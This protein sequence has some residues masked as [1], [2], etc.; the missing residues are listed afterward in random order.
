MW[1][2]SYVMRSQK[3]LIRV[4]NCAKGIPSMTEEKNE[5]SAFPV[6]SST[7]LLN[8]RKPL[9][10]VYVSLIIIKVNLF[11]PLSQSLIKP[12]VRKIFWLC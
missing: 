8:T 12:R 2:I 11:F 5:K 3:A 7:P 10:N 6:F 1:P 9:K 4:D